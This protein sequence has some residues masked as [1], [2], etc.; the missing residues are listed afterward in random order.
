MNLQSLSFF[1]VNLPFNNNLAV[2]RRIQHMIERFKH[3]T[4]ERLRHVQK[5]STAFSIVNQRFT[6]KQ[7]ITRSSSKFMC[8]LPSVSYFLEKQTLPTTIVAAVKN[9][10][11]ATLHMK[12]SLIALTKIELVFL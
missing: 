2:L 10:V 12:S 4:F 1:P 5:L 11:A 8:L 9:E 3:I 7:S 6:I